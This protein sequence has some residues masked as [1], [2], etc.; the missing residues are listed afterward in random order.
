MAT[1]NVG[2]LRR[3]AEDR[4]AE[5]PRETSHSQDNAALA[6]ELQVHQVELEM[7][8]EQLAA[9]DREL[10][11]VKQKYHD[12][13]EFAPVGYLVLGPHGIVEANRAAAELLDLSPRELVGRSLARFVMSVDADRYRQH[14]LDVLSADALKSCELGLVTQ[15][16]ERRDVRLHS[17]RSSAVSGLWRSALI[18]TTEEKRLARQLLGLTGPGGASVPGLAHDLRHLLMAIVSSAE[19]A[20][21]RLDAHS[22]AEP[23]LLA[24]KH[25]ALYGA[26]IVAGLL[27]KSA[28]EIGLPRVTNLNALVARAQPLLR[29]MAGKNI[30]MHFELRAAAPC[31][32][33][34]PSEVLQILLNLTS[35]ASDACRG[36]GQIVVSVNDVVRAPADYRGRI[37]RAGL[38]MLSVTDDGSGMSP[39]VQARAFEPRFTTKGPERG[40]GLGLASV[41][42]IIKRA[43]GDV[44][45]ASQLGRGTSVR[46]YLPRSE[47]AP[48]EASL[49]G[50]ESLS[51]RSRRRF[52]SGV[53]VVRASAAQVAATQTLLVVED[54]AATRAAYE[55]LL[56]DDDLRVIGVGSGQEALALFR[57]H[58]DSVCAVLCDFNLPDI[59]GIELAHQLREIR[60]HVPILFVSGRSLEDAGVAEMLDERTQ[61]LSKPVE[62]RQLIDVLDGLIGAG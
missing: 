17:K 27:G 9:L 12:L 22:A 61:L 18:D 55:E 47:L 44:R 59:Y 56:A 36:R 13:F 5:A 15:A 33:L 37:G 51:F 34:P 42:G 4:L 38:V 57:E 46:V 41:F 52:P 50:R 28:S 24:L 21:E 14:E 32:L 7:Q 60:N 54:D 2:A 10:D 62:V 19:L 30:Q 35:N 53:R 43:D 45:L 29:Q 48:A 8:V 40:T 3:S 20:L 39:E 16:G 11:V 26:S 23:P 31:V 6:H 58:A 25:A 49:T 1:P